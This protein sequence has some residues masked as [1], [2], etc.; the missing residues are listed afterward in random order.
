MKWIQGGNLFMFLG[1]YDYHSI[2]LLAGAI[3][4]LQSVDV[5]LSS[6]RWDLVEQLDRISVSKIRV[7]LGH[8]KI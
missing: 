3:E 2:G 4:C 8:N 7:M 1:S 6:G 5:T